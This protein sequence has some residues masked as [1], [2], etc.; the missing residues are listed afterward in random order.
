MHEAAP[1]PTPQDEQLAVELATDCSST[2]GP[3]DPVSLSSIDKAIRHLSAR[4]DRVTA[5]QREYLSRGEACALFGIDR[6]TLSRIERGKF[7]TPP[8]RLMIG[9]VPKYR[10]EDLRAWAAARPAPWG[11]KSADFKPGKVT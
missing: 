11:V 1:N 5:V 3:A 9:G 8:K 10:T 2:D 6:A 7:G 4:L